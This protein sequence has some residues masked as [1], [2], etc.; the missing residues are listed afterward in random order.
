MGA[1]PL[2]S[3][4]TGAPER[5]TVQLTSTLGQGDTL[6]ACSSAPGWDRPRWR[7]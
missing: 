7:K 3:P 5:P 6:P 4:L 1:T 2:V